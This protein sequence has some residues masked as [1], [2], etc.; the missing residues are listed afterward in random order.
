MAMAGHEWSLVIVTLLLEKG[1]TNRNLGT[2]MVQMQSLRKITLLL[3]FGIVMLHAVIPHLHHG[4]M[5]SEEHEALHTNACNVVDY[6]SIGFH[7]SSSYLDN[8]LPN[9][10]SN[11]PH[12]ADKT[13][14]SHGGFGINFDAPVFLANELYFPNHKLSFTC[15]KLFTANGLRAPPIHE[16]YSFFSTQLM[17]KNII[18]WTQHTFIWF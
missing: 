1:E 16:Y 7:S 15:R 6:L 5:M 2:L 9:H 11:K 4:E 3:A 13:L 14:V 10:Y 8:F 12:S 18:L 17:T